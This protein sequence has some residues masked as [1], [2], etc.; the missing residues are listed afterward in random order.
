MENPQEIQDKIESLKAELRTLGRKKDLA[1]KNN[2]YKTDPEYKA[3]LMERNKEYYQTKVRPF[4]VF[5][6]KK[7]ELKNPIV[8]SQEEK[9]QGEN[10]QGEN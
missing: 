5:K 8:K 2:K 10:P 7:C 4:K 6:Y 9:S 1:I 3:R